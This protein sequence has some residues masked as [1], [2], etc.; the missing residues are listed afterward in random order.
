[1]TQFD[2]AENNP[3][4][5]P[6]GDVVAAEVAVQPRFRVL[7]V[8]VGLIV[9]LATTFV[10]TFAMTMAFAVA[11]A[12]PIRP[13]RPPRGKRPS[14]SRRPFP[15]P[16]SA[17]GSARRRT[18]A[19][20]DAEPALR[21]GVSAFPRHAPDGGPV[22]VELHVGMIGQQRHGHRGVGQPLGDHQ[23]GQPHAEGVVVRAGVPDRDLFGL[24]RLERPDRGRLRRAPAKSARRPRCGRSA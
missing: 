6:A 18:R 15:R 13:W 20:Q 7:A 2:P 14:P 19:G 22:E 16:S 17:A 8:V 10:A 4:R 24:P 9:D 11:H 23:R 12:R 3:Y 5:S 21:R 1:M